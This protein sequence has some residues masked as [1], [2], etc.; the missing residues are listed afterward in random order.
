MFTKTTL[1]ASL[2][3]T[4]WIC[5][6]VDAASTLFCVCA[7]LFRNSNSDGLI[8]VK[9]CFSSVQSANILLSIKAT[10]IKWGR[11]LCL[12]YLLKLYGSSP[13]RQVGWRQMILIR[14]FLSHVCLPSSF[15]W[16]VMVDCLISKCPCLIL[17]L[18]TYSVSV[19]ETYEHWQGGGMRTELLWHYDDLLWVYYL[20]MYFARTS[21]MNSG[22]HKWR[23]CQ[24]QTMTLARVML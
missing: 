17:R 11:K 20:H 19:L 21:N 13:R 22:C 15:I 3:P 10:S 4:T 14:P 5:T 9:Q 24:S 18:H 16:F 23:V 8:N 2:W 1:T 6:C 7:Q 12:A